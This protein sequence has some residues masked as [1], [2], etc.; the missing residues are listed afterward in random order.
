MRLKVLA[1]SDTHLGE[2]TSLLSFPHGLQHLWGDLTGV[3]WK[4]LFPQYDPDRWNDPAQD[5]VEIEE[6]ILLG[7][8]PDRTLSSTSEI[9]TNTHALSQMLGS[10]ANVKKAVYIPGNHDHTLWTNYY[11]R[12][13]RSGGV[14]SS[15]ITSPTGDLVVEQGRRCDENNSAEEILSMFFGY[16]RGWAW[17]EIAQQREFDFAIANPLYAKQINGRTYAFTHGTHFRPEVTPKQQ[18]EF[19]LF[20]ALQLDWLIARLNIKPMGDLSKAR[21]LEDLERFVTPFVDSLWPS[22]KNEPTSRSDELW[23]LMTALRGGLNQRR[24]API[25]SEV[26]RKEKLQQAPRERINR[27]T[28]PLDESLKRWQ[29]YFLPYMLAYLKD[30]NLFKDEDDFTFVY[31]DTH[32][33]GWG[34]LPLDSGG[35][36]RIYNCGAWVVPTTDYDQ[37]DLYHP[38]C[39]IFAV[40]EEGEEYLFDVS[41][42]DATVDGESLLEL[43]ARDAENRREGMSAVA[44]PFLRLFG[45]LHQ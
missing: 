31:G 35:R 25:A 18:R 26:F 10:A 42:K 32:N 8:I 29:E 12:K 21:S 28:D 43:A 6:L 38:T 23:Y 16:P 9:Y 41:F 7:D 17:W 30:N 3:F 37:V 36:V 45:K 13:V 33:G 15:G 44:S 11:S 39:H 14:D 20:G 34:E 1:I 19:R 4:D 22:S 24:D 5:R 40:D 2:G 27:L